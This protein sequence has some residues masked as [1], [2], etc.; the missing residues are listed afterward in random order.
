MVE[1][2]PAIEQADVPALA[3]RSASPAHL[4]VRRF[5]RHRLAVFGLVTIIVLILLS[6]VGPI[7]SPYNS[8]QITIL[9]RFTPPFVSRH[10]LGTDELGRDLLTRLLS[11]GRISLTVGLAAMAMSITFG[12]LVGAIAGYYGGAVETVIM[13]F[14]DAVLCFPSIFLLLAL[15][16]FV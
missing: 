6:A 4:A 5:M 12:S 1:L 9:A 3:R 13:R 8:L 7:V 16:A 14:V 11:A 10:I 2:A 15:A